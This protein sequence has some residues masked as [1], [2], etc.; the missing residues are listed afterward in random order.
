MS[1]P[2]R[3]LPLEALSK[4]SASFKEDGTVTAGNASGMNDASSGVILASEEKAREL[5][6]PIL[7]RIISTAT[8]GVEPDIMGIGPVDAVNKALKKQD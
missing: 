5:G 6:L 2:E 7:A 3:M 1:I 8:V 4:L